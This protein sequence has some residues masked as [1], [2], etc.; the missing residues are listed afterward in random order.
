MSVHSDALNCMQNRPECATV[1]KQISYKRQKLLLFTNFC[2]F[3]NIIKPSPCETSPIY[4]VIPTHGEK[5]CIVRTHSMEGETPQTGWCYSLWSLDS[6]FN[7]MFHI[8]LKMGLRK[9]EHFNL[10][11]DQEII[12]IQI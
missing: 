3:Q 5:G 6:I 9:R 2:H 7:T 4:S 12:Y 11:V 8:A 10:D 1:L